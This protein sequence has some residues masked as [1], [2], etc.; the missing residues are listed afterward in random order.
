MQKTQTEIFQIEMSKALKLNEASINM[1]LLHQT[2]LHLAKRFHCQHKM[3]P[4][5]LKL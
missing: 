2:Q 4:L 5:F 3:F 1:I